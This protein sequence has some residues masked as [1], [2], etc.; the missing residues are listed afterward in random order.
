M[1]E[2]LEDAYPTAPLL[3]KDPFDR[4]KYHE[5]MQMVELYVSGATGNKP[6]LPIS[7]SISTAAQSSAISSAGASVGRGPLRSRLALLA[8]VYPRAIQPRTRPRRGFKSLGAAVITRAGLERRLRI[9]TGALLCKAP[10][11]PAQPF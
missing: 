7:G 8:P 3:P 5:L 2:Y 1:L 4:A 11:T 6:P 10:L 9:R